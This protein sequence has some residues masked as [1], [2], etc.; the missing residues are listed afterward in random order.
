MLRGAGRIAGVSCPDA[1]VPKYLDMGVQ[2]F[3]GSVN[4]LL[5]TSCTSYLREM[6]QAATAAGV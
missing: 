1:M 5:Q 3:H 4:S 2:Y 6:R